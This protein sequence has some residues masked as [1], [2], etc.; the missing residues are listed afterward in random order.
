EDLAAVVLVP[1][2]A[3]RQVLVKADPT[4]AGELEEAFAQSDS[5]TV[6][7]VPSPED[8]QE[9]EEFLAPHKRA[10]AEKELATW[11]DEPSRR[12]KVDESRFDEWFDVEF[13]S[14]VMSLGEEG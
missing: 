10:L 7:L 12:P 13:H 14:V 6:V 1:T 8:D 5:R 2:E 9:L 4:L 11:I 3:F